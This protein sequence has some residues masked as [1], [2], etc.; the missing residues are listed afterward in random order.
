MHVVSPATLTIQPGTVI[1]GDT[2][3]KN[4][5]LIINRGAKINA[6]GTPQLP[7]VFTSSAPAGQ[8]RSGDWGGLL[9]FGR[10]KINTPGFEAAQEGG[11]A[12]PNDKSN[13]YY[14]GTFEDDNSG[15]KVLPSRMYKLAM[16][17]MM[18]SNGLVEM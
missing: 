17:M 14:G 13:W 15:V 5:A 10:A 12:D 6:N 11:V 2:V 18:E 8:R 1:V 4:S 7:I 16:Q 9:I 3:G